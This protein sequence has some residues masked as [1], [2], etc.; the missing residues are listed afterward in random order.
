MVI[1]KVKKTACFKLTSRLSG[2]EN[3]VATLSELLL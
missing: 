2:N 3:R 1:K